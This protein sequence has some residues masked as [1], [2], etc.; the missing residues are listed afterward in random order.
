M[1]LLMFMT[2]DHWFINGRYYGFQLLIRSPLSVQE[3]DHH[4]LHTTSLLF[5][6]V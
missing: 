3:T 2:Q 1:A 6:M 5:E 4:L